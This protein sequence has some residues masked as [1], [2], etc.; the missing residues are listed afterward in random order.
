MVTKVMRIE[1]GAGKTR[2]VTKIVDNFLDSPAI[3]DGSNIAYFYCKQGQS[4][5][6]D[7]D[8]VLRS[9]VRQLA[10]QAEPAFSVLHREYVR[11]EKAGFPSDQLLR[12]ECE[13]VLK[14]IIAC[15]PDT[16][17]IL[18]ALDE[19]RERG[20]LVSTFRAFI[21]AGFPVKILISSRRDE[22]IKR[23]LIERSNI[24]ISAT[25]NQGDIDTYVQERIKI[26][27]EE[28]GVF[29]SPHLQEKI[30]RAFREKSQGM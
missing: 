24:G 23:M 22:D 1:A 13:K 19:C 3:R 27:R 15:N 30:M 26:S 12:D 6:Q 16:F 5:R 25:D 14:E 8:D 29:I 28:G 9:Y 7:P 20:N 4:G 21:K 17:L 10:S 2:L 11:N 18:D